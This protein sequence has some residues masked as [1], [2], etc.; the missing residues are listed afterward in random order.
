MD[1]DQIR[2]ASSEAALLEECRQ[3]GGNESNLTERMNQCVGTFD[4]CTNVC[5]EDY[6]V[7]SL[8]A[9]WPINFAYPIYGLVFPFLLTLTI[10]S[11]VFIVMVLSRKHMATSTNRCLLYMAIA[12]L[13]VGIIPFPFTFFYFTMRRYENEKSELK[14][15]WCYMAHYL[16]DALPPIAHNVAIW[17]TV[18][19]AFQRYI[20]ISNPFL[21][22]Q[23]CTLKRVECA[24]A[25]ILIGS[26]LF[27][28]LK[29]YD[30]EISFFHGLHPQLGLTRTC[31]FKASAMLN[32]LGENLVYSCYYWIRAIVYV[33]LPSVMLIIFNFLLMREVDA[34]KKR[35]KRLAL[36]KDSKA[37]AENYDINLMLV[38]IVTVFLVVNL[39]Q[40]IYFVL[41][42]INQSFELNLALFESE[43]SSL[44][45]MLDNM[46]ILATYPIN[47]TIYCS[48][49]S[50]FRDT[51]KSLICTSCH[52]KKST[53]NRSVNESNKAL[54]KKGS[55]EVTAASLA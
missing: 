39:P 26:L 24:S 18:L 44:F 50:Q 54:L 32:F 9:M 2:A 5:S 51:F 14:L 4:V 47:F 35:R 10:I 27:G 38:I 16:M 37:A 34:A 28:T 25:L 43:Y 36:Q 48:M 20:F 30:L 12:D 55:R 8:E 19:L 3:S 7:Q 1:D 40:G 46:L 13:F 17:L 45:L 53:F 42:C 52:S 22:R 49:S 6:W 11:N 23:L 33:F 41:V 15:W 31:M 21:A 29:F